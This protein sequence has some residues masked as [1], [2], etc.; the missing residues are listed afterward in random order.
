[1][2]QKL[3]VSDLEQLMQLRPGMM[4]RIGWFTYLRVM[5]GS[6][7]HA[8]EPMESFVGKAGYLKKLRE[9]EDVH[10]RYLICRIDLS[11]E[12]LPGL[13]VRFEGDRLLP[14]ASICGDNADPIGV[15]RVG[16]HR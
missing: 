5:F 6:T 15:G 14:Q 12:V 3:T 9:D 10:F 2:A 11:A 7:P 13:R 1:M 4:S 8:P 16:R